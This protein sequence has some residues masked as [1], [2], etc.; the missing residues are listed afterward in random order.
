MT[1]KNF[2]KVYTQLKNKPAKW[3]KVLKHN[4]P[5][6]RKFGRGVTSCDVCGTHRAHIKSYGLSICRHCFRLNAKELGFD[7]LS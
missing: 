4:K 7:K 3:K 2:N 6:K 5:K 1:T